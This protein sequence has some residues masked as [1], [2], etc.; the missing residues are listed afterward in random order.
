MTGPIPSLRHREGIPWPQAPLPRRWHLCSVWSWGFTPEGTP[1]GYCA[2]GARRYGLNGWWK[3]KN[4][5]RS[6][7]A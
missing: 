1:Y 6:W 2:C 4:R 5:R 7:Y 3:G